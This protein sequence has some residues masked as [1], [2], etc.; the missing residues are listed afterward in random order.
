MQIAFTVDL[1]RGNSRS[2]DV[3]SHCERGLIIHV[4]PRT[5]HLICHSPSG[6][7]GLHHPPGTLFVDDVMCGVNFIYANTHYRRNRMS[8]I[9]NNLP[10]LK[11]ME[12]RYERVVTDKV[13]KCLEM[14]NIKHIN[15]VATIFAASRP[16]MRRCR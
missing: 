9:V 2:S 11:W 3:T 16:R 13:G 7:I 8:G 6:Q 15:H 10:K 14:K 5:N 12:R 1:H 4:S